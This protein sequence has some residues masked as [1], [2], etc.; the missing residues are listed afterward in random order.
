MVA[1]AAWQ[2]WQRSQARTS[3]VFLWTH[4]SDVS[5]IYELQECISWWNLV[6]LADLRAQSIP[7]VL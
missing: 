4:H 6:N 7:K 5:F 2:Q 3:R 1:V